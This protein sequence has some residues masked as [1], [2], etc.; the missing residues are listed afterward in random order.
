MH[1]YTE[2]SVYQPHNGAYNEIT[3]MKEQSAT[4]QTLE[5]W[6]I[7]PTRPLHNYALRLQRD[8]YNT[9]QLTSW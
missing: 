5:N 3:Q 9:G 1:L 2:T 8:S 4:S 6:N 7:G